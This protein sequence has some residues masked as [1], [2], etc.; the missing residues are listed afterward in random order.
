MAFAA[1]ADAIERMDGYKAT[2]A[3]FAVAALRELAATPAS[4]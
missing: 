1:S 2:R 4:M 3:G